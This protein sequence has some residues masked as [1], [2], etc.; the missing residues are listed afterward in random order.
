MLKNVQLHTKIAGGF[1]L[2]GIIAL[3]VGGGGLAAHA[4]WARITLAG[5][6]LLGAAFA[7]WL[8]VVI[9]RAAAA[10]IA[11]YEST[12]ANK[13][14]WYESILDNIPFPLSVTD[15]DMNWTFINRPV[16]AFLGVKRKDVLGKKCSNWNA[17]ICNTEDCGITKLR[18]NVMQ[19]FFKQAGLNFQVDTAYVSDASGERVG[20]LE[21]VQDITAKVRGH[22]YQKVEVDRLAHN[23]TLLSCGNV[24]IDARVEDGDDLTKSERED[25]LII[26]SNL[27]KVKT[28]I[29]AL[30][31]D[32]NM[33]S[34]AAVEGRL[35]ARAE[36]AKHQGDFR[37]IVQGMNDTL[38]AIV[39]PFTIAAGYVQRIAKGDIPPKIAD[40]YKGAWNGVKESFNV[41]IDAINALV[42][43]ANALSQAAVEGRLDARGDALKHE[44]DF[45]KIVQGMNDTLDAVVQP[46]SVAADYLDRIAKG[47]IPPK[48][49][50]TYNGAWNGVKEN[51]NR[52]IDSLGG[53]IK[54]INKLHTE[55][56]AGDIEY[57]V[58]ADKFAGAYE[59]VAT[60]VNEIVKLHVDNILKI[61]GILSSYAEGDFSPVLERLPGKQVLANEKMDALRDSMNEVAHIAEELSC[62]NLVLAVRERSSKDNL[63]RAFATM[64]S[65][66]TEVVDGVRAAADNVAAGSQHLSS[67]SQEMS[68]GA[69]EQAASAEEVSSS[70]EQMVSNIRQNADNAQQTEKIAL[71]ASQDA[72]DGGKAVAETVA[73]MKE[74]ASKISIIE[75]IARQTNLLAL[76][77]A[78]EAARAGEH[79][80]GFAVVA[81][82]VRK[83]AERSQIA[84]GEIN[85][86]SATSVEVA[87]KAGEMLARI[88][89]D[90]QKTA[91]LVS[92]INAA[93]N[94]Q[95]TGAEQINK[96]IQQLDQVIQ[97]NA[98]ATEEMSA[99]SEELSSQAEQLQDTIGFFKVADNGAD[100]RARKA[101]KQI[102]AAM[103]TAAR[104]KGKNAG[105]QSGIALNLEKTTDKLDDEFERL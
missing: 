41:C 79:G 82:E 69:T 36:A 22:E 60:G 39:A 83:L 104:P 2:T 14:A 57:L 78:I 59:Q 5:V 55:Q 67:A 37:K 65:R 16:E 44:G 8:G 40:D 62:G 75:E 31:D 32:V 35:D 97:Q 29:E 1:V 92:E 80:K 23:L 27:G 48:I 87:E 66:L 94:E 11:W 9:A 4:A 53:L 15:S 56:K 17:N 63:M 102:N 6:G 12:M 64:V 13:I 20:H 68:Q 74:I 46:F 19:T 89:P 99:T 96:A 54:E 34:R 51:F 86:L 90:I 45:R 43:D 103:A 100:K 24:D 105:R 52:C 30:V 28:A 91:E 85:K 10:R 93:S 50:D 88:V 26:N 76:N 95:N 47:D 18:K 33:L 38:D 21:F 71:K 101:Q 77:A 61:L 42:A 73:A 25:F 49:T 98:S 7:V 3:V 72:K 84:A 81:S 70:M 58:P